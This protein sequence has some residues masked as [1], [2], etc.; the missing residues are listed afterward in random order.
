MA[1]TVVVDVLNVK[2]GFDLNQKWVVDKSNILYKCGWSPFENYEFNGKVTETF[3]SGN[4]VYSNGEFLT[5]RP[6]ER[7][8]FSR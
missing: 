5:S 4:H 8:I 6:G 1:D 7:L 3:V 2:D